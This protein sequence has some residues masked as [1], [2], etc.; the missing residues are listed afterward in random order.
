MKEYGADREM[1]MWINGTASKIQN[2]TLAYVVK[3]TAVEMQ[4]K[5]MKEVIYKSFFLKKK[6]SAKMQ[7]LGKG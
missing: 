5:Q 7:R 2:K 4:N 1:N 3:R 6:F